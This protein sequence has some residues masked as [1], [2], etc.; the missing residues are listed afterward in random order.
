MTRIDVVASSRSRKTG[1]TPMKK[2]S[3]S[4]WRRLLVLPAAALIAA[5][6]LM[7]ASAM[8][9]EG[10]S[11]YS[12]TPSTPKTTPTTPKPSTGT[13]PSKEEKKPSEEKASKE[14]TS[15]EPTSSTA[16]STTVGA[17]KSTT[18][19]TLPFTGLDLRL[20]VGVG[21]LLIAAGL[22]ITTLQRRHGGESR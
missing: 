9:A 1:V 16:P 20:V 18:A 22:S 4:R 6:L 7:P 15:K 2:G 11:G 14:P 19:S 8:A 17:S 13:S 12:Q 10:T 3:S 21:I 5:V